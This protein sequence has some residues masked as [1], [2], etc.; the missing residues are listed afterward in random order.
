MKARRTLEISFYHFRNPFEFTGDC[1]VFGFRR[2]EFL[3]LYMALC[4]NLFLTAQMGR[5]VTQEVSLLGE[6]N[7]GKSFVIRKR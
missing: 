2:P 6:R 1:M 4:T 7:R 5:E 3:F